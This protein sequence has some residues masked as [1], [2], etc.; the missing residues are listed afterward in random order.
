[1]KILVI[2]FSSIGDIIFTTP[3]IRC[4]KK[5]IPN[6]EIHFLT[7]EKMKVVTVYNPYIDQFHYFDG[8]FSDVQKKLQSIGFDYVIDLHKNFRTWR[9]RKSLNQA[10]WLI[11]D[12]ETFSKYLLTHF[13]IDKM[14]GVH[15]SDRSLETLKPL[16]IVD[17]QQGLDFF[18]PSEYHFDHSKYIDSS[19]SKYIA[20]VIGGSYATKRLTTA[21]IASICRGI[22]VPIVLIGGN[23]DIEA[24]QQILNQLQPNDG[25]I[26]NL[27]GQLNLFDSASVCK[28]A[29]LVISHDTGLLYISCALERPTMAIWCATSP[30]LDVWPYYGS[31]SIFTKNYS[32]PNL[33]CQPC[34]NFGTKSCPKK[35]FKCALEFDENTLISDANEFIT[36]L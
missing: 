36:N 32:V 12:K 5:Q 28:D 13:H 11:Y 20:F 25:T 29:S 4:L 33:A 35:H 27:C 24:A 7:K 21:K 23:D 9:L 3:V 31:K 1:M 16:Q 34:S 22:N 17:D 2:R 19:I 26:I 18:F 14:R 6:V 10:K 30:K 15:I 8:N